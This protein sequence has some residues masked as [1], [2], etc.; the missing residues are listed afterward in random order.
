M[1]GSVTILGNDTRP[2]IGILWCGKTRDKLREVELLIYVWGLSNYFVTAREFEAIARLSRR[3]IKI[4]PFK[5]AYLFG[6]ELGHLQRLDN[7]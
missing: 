2:S 3:S 5:S 6:D 4:I 7:N 1:P